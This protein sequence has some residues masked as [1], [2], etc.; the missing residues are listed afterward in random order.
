MPLIVYLFTV[1]VV[2]FWLML[3]D[4]RRAIKKAWRIPEAVLL[5]CSIIG[6]S[7]G[8]LMGMLLCRHKTRHSRFKYG[9][10]FIFMVHIAIWLVLNYYK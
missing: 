3:S 6:G 5:G 7:A 2:S 8:A 4:K 9:L 1:N 10:P